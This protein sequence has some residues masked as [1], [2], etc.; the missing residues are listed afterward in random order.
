M[1]KSRKIIRNPPNCVDL[2]RGWVYNNIV[3]IDRLIEGYKDKINCLYDKRKE[4]ER[5]YY[6]TADNYF[7]AAQ[8]LFGSILDSLVAL[9]EVI[10]SKN[11][12]DKKEAN[13]KPKSISK[14]LTIDQVIQY[15]DSSAA[16]AVVLCNK[17]DALF[18]KD[19]KKEKSSSNDSIEQLLKSA[20]AGASALLVI[21]GSML[22]FATGAS[23]FDKVNWPAALAGVAFFATFVAGTLAI[24]IALKK[25]A[26]D[27]KQFAKN[28]K[29][30]N[31]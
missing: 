15:N 11:E 2:W 20:G 17:L 1:Q 3:K 25:E 22:L 21:A 30:Y 4:L 29:Y 5:E 26:K 8:E 24:S 7:E 23:L 6:E 28:V 9:Q 12:E 19:K 10:V 14:T 16:A 27:L 31:N 13:K 18:G